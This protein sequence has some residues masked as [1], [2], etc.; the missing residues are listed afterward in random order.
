[1]ID[2]REPC[3]FENLALA[4]R[5][6]I[7]DSSCI[8]KQKQVHLKRLDYRLLVEDLGKKGFV[9]IRASDKMVGVEISFKNLQKH[10][11]EKGG[12]F[13]DHGLMLNPELCGY[14][15]SQLKLF[16]WAYKSQ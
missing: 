5:D 15:E 2:N 1:M 11:K 9:N 6:A 14:F 16:G 3:K 10:Y 8:D 13:F 4:V 12:K 7:I